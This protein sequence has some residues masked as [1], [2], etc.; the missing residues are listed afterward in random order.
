MI[1]IKRTQA[2]LFLLFVL[3]LITISSCTKTE[4]KTSSDCQSRKCSLSKCENKKCVYTL[5]KNCCGNHINESLEDGKPGGKC[6]C[7]Q[8]YGK[9]EGKGKVKVG[10]RIEDTLYGHYYCNE[11][12]QC[13]FGVDKKDVNV[14][15]FLDSI[16]TGFFKAS[17]ILKYNKPF[18]IN[19]NI[20]EIKIT[21]DD[22]SKDLILPI[23]FTNVKLFYSTQNA[24]TEL[25]I[26]ENGISEVLEGIRDEVKINVP[27]N[28]DYRPQ[29][30]EETGSIRYSIGYIY[31]KQVVT[32]KAAD[33]NKLYGKEEIRDT[34]NAP[35]KQVFFVRSEVE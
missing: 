13:V 7:P 8:D 21:L 2:I 28:L 35:S 19:N 1:K 32:G 29:Q 15:N 9:C 25:L 34:F 30:L 31:T 12:E 5:Q 10:A 11:N 4:C 27:L 6:T 17:S 20:F 16:N 18:D 33:G 3:A 23:K 14:Q 22:I 24:R 26:A